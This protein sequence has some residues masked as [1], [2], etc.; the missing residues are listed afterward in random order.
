MIIS[1]NKGYLFINLAFILEF[2][3]ENSKINEY[4]AIL[5]LL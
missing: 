1:N 5:N 4:L 3:S 2:I